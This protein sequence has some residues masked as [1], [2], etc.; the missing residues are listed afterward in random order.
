MTDIIQEFLTVVKKNSEYFRLQS[1][2]GAFKYAYSRICT[3][4]ARA[5]KRFYPTEL[6]WLIAI[7]VAVIDLIKNY[8]RSLPPPT[9]G[10]AT[11]V[12]A[13]SCSAS[14]FADGSGAPAG[15]EA[16]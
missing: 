6:F 11:P 13:D 3:N 2:I 12:A 7:S 9:P 16:G 10:D 5:G 15:T 4:K 14:G 8:S 1:K